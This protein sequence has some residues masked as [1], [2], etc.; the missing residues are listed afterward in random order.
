VECIKTFGEEARRKETTRRPRR[1]CGDNIETDLT[2]IGWDDGLDSSGS[3]FRP[4]A[5]S[6]EFGNELL[7]SIKYWEIPE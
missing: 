5:D 7:G 1:R 4:P 3:E 6:C 2:E